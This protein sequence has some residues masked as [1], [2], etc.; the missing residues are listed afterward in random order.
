MKANLYAVA[1]ISVLLISPVLRAGDTNPA[2]ASPQPNREMPRGG[3]SMIPPQ[4][5]EKL[6][7]TDDQKAKLKSIEENFSKAQ[8]EY[9]ATH[10]DEIAAARKA[11][12]TAMAGIQEQRKAAMEEIKALLTK[13]QLDSL[14]PKRGDGP[15]AKEQHN[16]VRPPPAE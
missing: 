9:Y 4:L 14:Q 13:E 12:E 15:P 2:P 10:K 5:V 8:Q 6:N 11:M 16:A 7:L 3:F 1:A